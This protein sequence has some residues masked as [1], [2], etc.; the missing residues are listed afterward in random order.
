M[1]TLIVE[2]REPKGPYGAKG[3]GEAAAIPST[4]AVI[5]AIEDAVGIRIYELPATAEK[6]VRAL[7][8]Q[9]PEG[10]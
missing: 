5:N 7:K 1:E 2:E 9:K 10:S 6:I 8:E 4:P 3:V